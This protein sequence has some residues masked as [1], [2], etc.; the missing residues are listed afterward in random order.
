MPWQIAFE[1]VGNMVLRVMG[2]SVNG[3]CGIGCCKFEL[4][5]A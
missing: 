2:K 4:R 3:L 1:E 5:Q